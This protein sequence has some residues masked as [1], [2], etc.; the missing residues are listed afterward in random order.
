VLKSRFA[1]AGACAAGIIG[2]L[3][4]SSVYAAASSAAPDAPG[5][6][7]AAGPGRIVISNA[8][9]EGY[10]S[11]LTVQLDKPVS[12]STARQ[13][14]SSLERAIRTSRPD[15]GPTGGEFLVC[16]KV[17]SFSDFDGT[18][19]IQHACR[20][21][22]GPWGYKQS[23]GLCAITISDVYEHGMAW[24]RNG[25]RQGTQ[26]PH[27]EYC[28][29]QFHGNYNPEHDFDT[30]AYNDTLTFRVDVGGQTGNATLIA[31]GSFYSA[32]C[33]NPSV[34]P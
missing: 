5:L 1:A 9:S 4:V 26:S 13:I 24:T 7:Q 29:Y 6:A 31:S 33:S 20:G 11:S 22:T 16:N 10:K 21:T 8:I 18:Y 23:P 2:I 12:A 15:A 3:G 32:V 30:I 34:C 19:T 14:K 28:G 17:H 27:T 25:T